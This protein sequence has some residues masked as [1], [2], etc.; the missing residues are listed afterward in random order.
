MDWKWAASLEQLN[1]NCLMMLDIFSNLWTSLC[2]CLCAWEITKNVAFSNRR[3]CINKSVQLHQ[4]NWNLASSASR[5][6]AN[7][8]RELSMSLTLGISMYTIL[9]HALYRVSSQMLVLKQVQSNG[10]DN[11]FKSSSLSVKM[12]SL[13]SSWT[14][15]ILCTRQK[16]LAWDIMIK[17]VAFQS[18]NWPLDYSEGLLLNKTDSSG[19]LS[20]VHET[21]HQRHRSKPEW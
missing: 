12:R 14:K 6:S 4:S 20:Q 8:L 9:D 13:W 16:I 10:L 21:Q 5:I 19:D 3:T 1:L 17:L 18:Q 15:S 7:S 11:F 2:W